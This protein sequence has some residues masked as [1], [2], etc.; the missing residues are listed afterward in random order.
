LLSRN[1]Y[2]NVLNNAYFFGKRTIV[3][4]TA[5]ENIEK[6]QNNYRNGSALVSSALLHL[7]FKLWSFC[8]RGAQKYF[9]SRAQST[10]ATLLLH[11]SMSIEA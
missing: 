3:I 10:V 6:Q 1:L 5:S 4:A 7:T 9:L 8:W 2:Q 11:A